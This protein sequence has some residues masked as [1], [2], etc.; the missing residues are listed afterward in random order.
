V[1]IAARDPRGG[2]LPH[3]LITG[4][5]AGLQGIGLLLLRAT[6]GAAL[7]FQGGLCLS[8]AESFSLPWFSCVTSVLA[9]ALLLA[10][11]CTPVG[12]LI[13]AGYV[14]ALGFSIVPAAAPNLFEGRFT[15]ILSLSVLIAVLLLGPGAFSW[16]GRRYGR[17]EIIIPR[18][19]SPR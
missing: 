13:A 3:R 18:S 4:F 14:A 16:D 15:D 5:P 17:R 19:E 12:A 10:G 11:F 1:R 8:N 2:Q 9:G 6:L 7:L